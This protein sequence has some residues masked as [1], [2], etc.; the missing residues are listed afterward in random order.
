M[1]EQTLPK[2]IVHK[3]MFMKKF[4]QKGEGRTIVMDYDEE[5]M[6]QRGVLIIS[7]IRSVFGD[8]MES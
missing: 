7:F 5:E 4:A 8:S 6:K 2:P 3:L 1:T